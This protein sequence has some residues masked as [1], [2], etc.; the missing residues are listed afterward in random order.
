MSKKSWRIR[1]NRDKDRAILEV[2]K[3]ADKPMTSKEIA[4]ALRKKGLFFGSPNEIGQIISAR[5][6][7]EYVERKRGYKITYYKLIVSSPR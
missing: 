7:Y 2:L 5:L 1:K 6:L 3:E 4:E